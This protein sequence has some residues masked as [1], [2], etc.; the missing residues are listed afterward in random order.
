[1]KIL[2]Q[3]LGGSKLYGLDTP[4]SDEDIRYVFLNTELGQIIGLDRFEHLDK[5]NKD[6]DSFGME[7][8]G[9]LNLLRKTNTQVLELLYTPLNTFTILD[10]NFEVHILNQRNKFIDSDR[11]YKSLKGYIFTE[12]RLVLGE[13]KGQIGGKRYESVE[14]YGY[15][16][17]NIVQLFRLI[18]AGIEF[19]TSGIFPTNIKTYN[20]SIWETL[21]KIKTEPEKYSSEKLIKQTYL[22]EN[23]LDV[24]Y[25]NTRIK[26]NFNLDY[27][28][29]VCASLYEPLLNEYF[30]ELHI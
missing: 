21:I 15:S 6:E 7:L 14:K 24:V 2:C 11:F 25:A 20:E 12:R 28:N 30:L 26:Y 27:A 8:R 9:F 29:W 1:M 16:P 13:R 19:F 17:K 10:N 3:Y 22:L 4:T 5:R 18:Y 23:Q